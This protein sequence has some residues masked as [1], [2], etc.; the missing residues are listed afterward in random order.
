MPP[1]PHQR[2]LDAYHR[3]LPTLPR[4]R[5]WGETRRTHLAARWGARPKRQTVEWW[6]SLFGFIAESPF[7]LG[8][9]PGRPGQA[10]FVMTLPWLVKS[11]ENLVKVI[12][13]NY[14]R[15]TA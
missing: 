1:C 10:P 3:A 8:H 14:H 5:E 9:A 2:I 7:L 15:E 4:V 11:E 12:E 6:E 13:G